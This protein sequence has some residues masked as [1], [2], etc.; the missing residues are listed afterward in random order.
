MHE[1]ELNI[2]PAGEPPATPP[3]RPGEVSRRQ[4]PGFL[5][6]VRE[7]ARQNPS[8]FLSAVFIDL[9]LGRGD[10]AKKE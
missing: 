3:A 4:A 7:V 2:K 9:P 1:S 10:F 8:G 6:T 5:E